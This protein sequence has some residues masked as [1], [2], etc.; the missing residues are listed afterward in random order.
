MLSARLNLPP[1][2]CKDSIE[3]EFNGEPAAPLVAERKACMHIEH[4]RPSRHAPVARA[5]DYMFNRWGRFTR[6]LTTDASA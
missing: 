6:S 5:M 3:R 4:T 2:D 1:A